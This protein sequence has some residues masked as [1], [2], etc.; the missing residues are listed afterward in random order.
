[1][2]IDSN[3]FFEYLYG[4]RKSFVKWLFASFIQ[5][6][7]SYSLYLFIN[8]ELLFS[9][10]N[11]NI[12]I[13][14]SFVST[15]VLNILII[16][17]FSVIFRKRFNYSVSSL[18]ILL[19]FS[20]NIIISSIL[21]FLIQTQLHLNSDFLDIGIQVLIIFLVPCLYFLFTYERELLFNLGEIQ[22]KIDLLEDSSNIA[23]NEL[24][25]SSDTKQQLKVSS[26]NLICIKSD[27]NYCNVYYIENNTVKTNLLRIS[28]KNIETQLLNIKEFIRCH[29]SFII[30]VKYLSGVYGNSKAYKFTLNHV[31]FE[32]PVSRNFP[33]EII[34][35]LKEKS[36]SR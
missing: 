4:S 1:M 13:L 29:N 11:S 5:A 30:N 28:M 16:S 3:L 19:Y 2:K 21:T 9:C 32:I 26:E 18:F 14:A 12:I 10:A 33:K 17:L 7:Y 8:S 35:T 20:V 25:I 15:L 23:G 31:D 6:I 24:T 34:E 27:Q 22:N 36:L